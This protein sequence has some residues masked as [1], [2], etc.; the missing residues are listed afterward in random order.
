MNERNLSQ[1]CQNTRQECLI[2]ARSWVS[3]PA[4]QNNQS[5]KQSKIKVNDHLNKG[6]IFFDETFF[7]SFQDNTKKEVNLFG[8]DLKYPPGVSGVEMG[9]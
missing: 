9:F 6:K 2:C 3:S 8:L 7:T 1:K 4:P 5:I